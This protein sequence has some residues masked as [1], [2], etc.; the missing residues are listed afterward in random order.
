GVRLPVSKNRYRTIDS[1]LD[2]LNSTLYMPFGVRR[3]T[4][5]M[6]RTNIED[7]DQLQHM[8][9]YVA[10]SSKFP[11]GINMSA[12]ERFAKARQQAH[13]KL[14]N[15]TG[16][17]QSFWVPTSPSY[18]QKLR[19][20]RSLGLGFVPSKQVFF[21]LNGTTKLYRALLNPA[22][23]PTMEKLM[24]DVSE[25][26]E[27]AIHRLCTLEGK[28]IHHVNELIAIEPPKV[29]AVPLHAKPILQERRRFLPPIV[30]NGV[31]GNYGNCGSTISKYLDY[32]SLSV[33]SL[34]ASTSSQKSEPENLVEKPRSSIRKNLRKSTGAPPKLRKRNEKAGILEIQIF[35]GSGD[36]GG[37]G[38][39]RLS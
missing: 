20:S 21:V 27:I 34:T 19:M 18:K 11:R 17:G 28:R 35:K 22:R 2:D 15:E 37:R 25:G 12:L 9:K 31:S 10:T 30:N 33:T 38:Q 39:Q 14:S 1:L 24:S 4:T 7:L 36:R 8:G 6:G 13:A 3:L 5:P 32:I 29:I 16:G 26:L 23:L